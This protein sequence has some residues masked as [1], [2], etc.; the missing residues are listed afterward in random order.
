MMNRPTAYRCIVG[1][2][3]KGALTIGAILYTSLS[4]FSEPAPI[5]TFDAPG[6][7]TG[8]GQGTFAVNLNEFGNAIGWFVDGNT[9]YHGFIRYPNGRVATI[10]APGA[11]ATP[12]SGQGTLAYSINIEG[13]IAGQYQDANY[14]YHCFVRSPDGQIISFDPPGAGTGPN[15]GS[16]AVDINLEGTIA[17]YTVDNN[18]VLHG[19]L[20]SRWGSFTTFDAPN[21]G[22]GP[23][24]GTVVTLE[25]GLNPQGALIG[26]YYDANNAAHGYVRNRSGAITSL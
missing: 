20:R 23:F 16:V 7:G 10:D 22:R 18:N 24:Q 21:A 13:R 2:S 1:A 4:G 9:A 15:Q 17:G 19:F 26:W 8:A 6:A 11:G 14:V 12:G 25:S 3:Q 5:I